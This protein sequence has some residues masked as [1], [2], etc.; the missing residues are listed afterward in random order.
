MEPT[1]TPT[2]SHNILRWR[3]RFSDDN[4]RDA[5]EQRSDPHP[6]S[7]KLWYCAT[8]APKADE[9]VRERKTRDFQ[10]ADVNSWAMIISGLSPQRDRHPKSVFKNQ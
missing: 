4:R 5:C 1:A 10:G 7:A 2:I 3:Q 9:P 8:S 6:T